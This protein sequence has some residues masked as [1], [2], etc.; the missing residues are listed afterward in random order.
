MFT[1]ESVCRT[2]VTGTVSAVIVDV[3]RLLIY[4]FGF[5]LTSFSFI[6]AEIGG[7]VIA[8]TLAAFFGSFLGTRLVKK[9]TLHA[10]QRIVGGMLI[11]VGLGMASGLL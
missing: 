10:V 7:L 2:G 4:G 5:Y 1:S 9:V 6:N 11:L 3:A 8:A